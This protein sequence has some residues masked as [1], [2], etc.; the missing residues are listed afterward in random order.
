MKIVP[1]ALRKLSNI[2][3]IWEIDKNIPLWKPLRFD[4]QEDGVEN[5]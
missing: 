2:K 5:G 4:N 1:R 3:K